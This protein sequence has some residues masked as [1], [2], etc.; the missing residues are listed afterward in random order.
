MLIPGS[1]SLATSTVTP[2]HQ[3]REGGG[4]PRA[5]HGG[6]GKG[7]RGLFETR[8]GRSN[9]NLFSLS[10]L[11]RGDEEHVRSVDSETNRETRR[12]GGRR[13]G[14]AETEAKTRM[15]LVTVLVGVCLFVCMCVCVC[16]CVCVCACVRACVRACTHREQR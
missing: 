5:G 13:G 6:R 16:V 3:A 14:W 15:G 10:S 8:G 12:G 9:P 1:P 4:R 2:L 7:S 11:G